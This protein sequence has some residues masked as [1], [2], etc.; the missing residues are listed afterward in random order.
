MDNEKQRSAQEKIYC[1]IRKAL[2]EKEFDRADK[3]LEL[4][5]Q[6]KRDAEWHFLKGCLLTNIGWFH[7]AQVHFQTA[8]SLEPDNQEYQ[9]ASKSLENS[10]NGYKDT[11]S[12]PNSD[13]LNK[14][15]CLCSNCLLDATCCEGC[16]EGCGEG[17]C[18]CLCEGICQGCDGI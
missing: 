10:A 15:H 6:D 5:L 1:D 11:W 12:E 16:A 3:L 4:I 14:K 13:K 17:V 8:C 9:E 2:E 18:E 7:D